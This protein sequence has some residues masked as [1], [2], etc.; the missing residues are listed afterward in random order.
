MPPAYAERSGVS[1]I[2]LKNFLP[3]IHN[4]KED[5]FMKLKKSMLALTAVAVI[6]V[7]MLCLY[8]LKLSSDSVTAFGPYTGNAEIVAAASETCPDK[9]NTDSECSDKKCPRNKCPDKQT[10]D[11]D[12]DI[13]A[14]PEKDSELHPKIGKKPH[15][16]TPRRP[17]RDS[18]EL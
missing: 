3:M 12:S 18:Q 5:F 10:D 17:H 1:E 11:S 8:S 14:L 6:F 2:T 4:Q 13:S 15:H 9:D 16:G 7:T